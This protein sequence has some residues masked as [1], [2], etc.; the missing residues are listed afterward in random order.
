MISLIAKS[1]RSCSQSEEIYFILY[2]YDVQ[3]IVSKSEC[4]QM[5][6]ISACNAMSTF[7]VRQPIHSIHGCFMES[8]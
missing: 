3:I 2:N 6:R 5:S 7:L 8:T 1:S 4:R